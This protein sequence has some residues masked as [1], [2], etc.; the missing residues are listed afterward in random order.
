MLLRPLDN[1]KSHAQFLFADRSAH[2][3]L[4]SLAAL[5]Y[6]KLLCVGTPRC[7]PL[8]Q[9]WSEVHLPSDCSHL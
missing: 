5:G 8:I 4:D 9:L 6:R 1:K 7:G 2:F 3:L